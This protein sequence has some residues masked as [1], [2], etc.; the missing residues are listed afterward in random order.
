MSEEMV[1]ITLKE[2]QSL[3]DDRKWRECLESGG[4]DNWEWFHESL[5]EGGYYEEEE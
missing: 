3:L 1:T 2:Y 5:Q 4:V